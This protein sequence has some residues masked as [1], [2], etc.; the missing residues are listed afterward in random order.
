MKPIVFLTNEELERLNSDYMPMSVN[1]GLLPEEVFFFCKAVRGG[2]CSV[3]SA[4]RDKGYKNG[5][6]I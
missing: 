5:N 4:Y 2:V 1:F 3:C 6:T